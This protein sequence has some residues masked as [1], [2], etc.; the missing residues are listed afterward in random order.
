MLLELI[1]ARLAEYSTQIT[2]ARVE[3]NANDKC[4]FDA[5][6]DVGSGSTLDFLAA[7]IPPDSTLALE[8]PFNRLEGNSD[9]SVRDH[10]EASKVKSSFRW[11]T[12]NLSLASL[13]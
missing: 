5:T 1:I 8:A 10:H 12:E 2:G 7:E 9:L 13:S 11:N 6:Q 3:I 4:K